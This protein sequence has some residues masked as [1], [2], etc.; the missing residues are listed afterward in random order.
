MKKMNQTKKTNDRIIIDEVCTCGALK[1][2][3]EDD[4]QLIAHGVT[5]LHTGEC[6]ATN[7]IR[8]TWDYYIYE[9]DLLTCDMCGGYI[10][11]DRDVFDGDTGKWSCMR[12]N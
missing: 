12:C 9:D 2:K 3:H 10:D 7:C 1:S 8:F 6:R 11:T 5:G 4:K